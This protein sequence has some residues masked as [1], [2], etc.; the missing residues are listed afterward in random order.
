MGRAWRVVLG[1]QALRLTGH[2][3][4]WP[5]QVSVCYVSS[6]PHSLNVSCRDLV[7]SGLLLYLCDSF[8]GAGFLKKFHFLK[9]NVLRWARLCLTWVPWGSPVACTLVPT[10]REGVGPRGLSR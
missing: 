9:G 4:P 10:G 1:P 7:F 5:F 6:R 8:V 3:L 2:C